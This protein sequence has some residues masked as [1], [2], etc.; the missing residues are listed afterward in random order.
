MS[1]N[2]PSYLVIGLALFS[3]FFGSGNLIFPLLL[4]RDAG[5]LFPISA[6]GFIVSAVLI[7]CFGVLAIALAQGDYEKIFR[8]SLGERLGKIVVFIVLLS[9]IPFGAAPRCV[10]LAHASLKTFLP[11]PELWLFAVVFLGIVA[12]LVHDRLHLV[13]ILG[14][15]LTPLLLGSVAVIVAS[16]MADGVLDRPNL[17]PGPLFLTSLLEGYNTQD[18]L[19]SLFFSS[20]LILLI[21]D[22]FGTSRELVRAVLK[23]SVVGITLLTLLYCL[24]IAAASFHSEVLTGRSGIE[25][26]SILAEHS[27]GSRFGLIAGLAVALACLT[28]AVALVMA[29]HDFLRNHIFKSHAGWSLGVTLLSI[30]GTTLLEFDGIMAIISPMMKVVYPIILLVVIYYLVDYRKTHRPQ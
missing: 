8:A 6:L 28:T 12:Y 17:E 22:S 21:K 25:L 10:V 27:L 18:L 24:L 20:S 26:V 14:K 3:M 1:N 29:F 9:F 11:M 2:K 23:G 15:F 4:G 5:W 13:D 30:F 7:P 16:A 19:S